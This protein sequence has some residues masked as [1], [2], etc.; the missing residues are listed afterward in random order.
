M[1]LHRQMTHRQFS[2]GENV[3]VCTRESHRKTKPLLILCCTFINIHKYSRGMDL[4]HSLP[5]PLCSCLRDMG[6]HSGPDRIFNVDS[7]QDT[8]TH[9]RYSF[10]NKGAR[11][12][13]ERDIFWWI[14]SCLFVHLW[15]T[16][17]PGPGHVDLEFSQELE[18]VSWRWEEI[19]ELR[20]TPY[21][22]EKNMWNTA[23]TL[24][25]AQVR[26]G[27]TGAVRWHQDTLPKKAIQIKKENYIK[28]KE[29]DLESDAT[30]EPFLLAF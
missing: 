8:H 6:A 29:I 25:W 23:Q 24:T 13:F 1:T 20:G 5:V 9:T 22:H 30:E 19:R 4:I 21:R 12:I 10:K 11:I 18:S 2:I 16:L 17:Y 28:I 26:T 7:K 15:W 14:E 3:K 27:N